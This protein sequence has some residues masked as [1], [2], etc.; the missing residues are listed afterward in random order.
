MAQPLVVV[1]ELSGSAA[2]VL[3]AAA[4]LVL[5]AGDLGSETLTLNTLYPSPL[6][7]YYELISTGIRPPSTAVDTLLS[8]DG[9]QVAIGTNSPTTTHRLTVSNDPGAAVQAS[10]YNPSNG[11][12]QVAGLRFHTQSGW[13]V[14]LRTNQGNAWL[15]LTDSAGTWWAR[16]INTDYWTKGDVGVGSSPSQVISGTNRVNLEVGG[17]GKLRAANYVFGAREPSTSGCVLT[18]VSAGT[19]ACSATRY[20][21]WIAG[22]RFNDKWW[23][24]LPSGQGGTIFG[25][26]SPATVRFY[27][28]D[29]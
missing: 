27:C 16:W 23:N 1:F 9:G 15:E 4:V 28:C 18:T 29:P 13:N 3:I 6:G 24:N 10:I 2:R 8:R 25:A 17:G 14:M 21:T 7:L 26:Y 22:F 12:G 19:T 11:T 20:A 5:G